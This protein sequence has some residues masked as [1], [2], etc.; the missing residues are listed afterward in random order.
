MYSYKRQSHSSMNIYT[1]ISW[2]QQ[3]W[4]RRFSS[5]LNSDVKLIEE[6]IQIMGGELY[7][8]FFKAFNYYVDLTLRAFL[9]IR[10][11]YE[12]FQYLVTLMINLGLGCHDRFQ[13]EF[14]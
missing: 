7:Y 1:I 8:H 10:H 2:L 3:I 4:K 11:Y 9:A 5:I 14:Y 6:M 12:H 13:E